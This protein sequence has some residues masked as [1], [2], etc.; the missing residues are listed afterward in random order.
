MVDNNHEVELRV[1]LKENEHA[2]IFEK[3]KKAGAVLRD[4]ENLIDIYFC[5]NSI[6][7]FSGVEMDEVIITSGTS[8]GIY[9]AL[10][11]LIDPGDE[12]IIFDPY[13][14]SYKE[15]AMLVGAKVEYIDTYPDF[16]PNIKELKKAITPQ[17]KL[18]IINSPNNP[19]GAVYSEK[20]IREIVKIARKNNIFILSDEVYE[21]FIYKGKHFSPA[22]IYNNVITLNGFSKSAS[23]TGWRVVMPPVRKKSLRE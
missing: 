22:S 21:K 1:L 9:L 14:V 11:T 12:I 3:L 6:T 16:Q 23:M 5:S 7:S 15:L 20:V 4:E 10:L 13:F 18:I 2:Q 8:G 19:T 17:T